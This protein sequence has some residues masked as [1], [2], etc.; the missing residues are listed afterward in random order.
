MNRKYRKT[1]FTY[2]PSSTIV[3]KK[4]MFLTEAFNINV[5]KDKYKGVEEVMR[6]ATD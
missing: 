3:G 6:K 1:S 5:L 2:Q 4:N